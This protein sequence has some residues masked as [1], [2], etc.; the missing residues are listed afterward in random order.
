MGASIER[1]RH[2]FLRK[3][4]RGFLAWQTLSGFSS[5]VSIVRWLASINGLPCQQ[6]SFAVGRQAILL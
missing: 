1:W 4:Q 5:A 6:R 3:I 2:Q